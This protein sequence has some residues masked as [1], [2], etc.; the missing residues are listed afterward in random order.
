MMNQWFLGSEIGCFTDY[1][2]FALPIW[3]KNL[4]ILCLEKPKLP[5][6]IWKMLVG[7]KVGNWDLSYTGFLSACHECCYSLNLRF[8]SE[9]SDE[10]E[11]KSWLYSALL[12]TAPEASI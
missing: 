10:F 7:D 6:P 1:G 2:T 9:H 11:K 12:D 4:Q 3:P 5:F 8:A